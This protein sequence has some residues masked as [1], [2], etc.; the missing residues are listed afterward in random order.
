MYYMTLYDG[1]NFT[2]RRS[3]DIAHQYKITLPFSFTFISFKPRMSVFIDI[4]RHV[5][6]TFHGIPTGI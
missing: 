6:G 4:I 5:F 1:D 3:R 2:G